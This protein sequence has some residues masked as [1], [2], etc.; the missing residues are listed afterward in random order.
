MAFRFH[1]AVLPLLRPI[2][3]VAQHPRN[4]NNGD[5][6]ALVEIIET[7]GYTVPVLVQAS[8]GYIVAG[9]TRYAAL[10]ALGS[11]TIPVIDLD[12]DDDTALR[13]LTGDN[14]AARKAWL[15]YAQELEN[16]RLLRQS[17]T[18][19]LGTGYDE[20]DM[21]WLATMAEDTP[22]SHGGFYPGAD[23]SEEAVLGE[24]VT[25]PECGHSFRPEAT[26][27]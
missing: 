7:V 3:D 14:R 17:E 18:D 2:E 26:D 1:D 20:P 21:A 12:V 4:A 9:N 24:T 5:V 25:C 23:H 16:L 15:D 22:S 6:D 10:L 19:L 8:T 27:A 13:I 11:S